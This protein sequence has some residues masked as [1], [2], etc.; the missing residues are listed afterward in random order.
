MGS[1][2]ATRHDYVGEKAKFSFFQTRRLLRSEHPGFPSSP[3]QIHNLVTNAGI[4]LGWHWVYP[5]VSATTGYGHSE[6]HPGNLM[7]ESGST[8]LLV[9]TTKTNLFTQLLKTSVGL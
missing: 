9:E 8:V 3:P 5:E 2:W 4:L 7:E 6:S 1:P